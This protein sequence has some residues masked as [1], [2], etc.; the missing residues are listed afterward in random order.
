MAFAAADASMGSCCLEGAAFALG[1][2]GAFLGASFFATVPPFGETS[3]FTTGF[4][5]GAVF[6]AGVFFLSGIIEAVGK[7]EQ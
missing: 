6:F 5:A 4:L 1:A 7:K 3:F 2:G